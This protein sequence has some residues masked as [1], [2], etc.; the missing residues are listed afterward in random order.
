M[1]RIDLEEIQQRIN[2]N[3]PPL[4]EQRSSDRK[5]TAENL[6]AR[7][8][9]WELWKRMGEMYGHTWASQQGDEPN[10][11][12][13]RGLEGV[14]ND[15]LAAGLRGC[16]D[17]PGTFPPTL[18]EF[19]QMCTGYDPTAWE[20]QHHKIFESPPMIEDK[21]KKERDLEQ[22]KAMLAQLREQVGI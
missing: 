20:R 13:I 14:S 16:L 22:R 3:L 6:P 8:P 5:L 9:L 2:Q 12:W 19:R 17:R 15:Q 10:N 11:T 4:N 18:P 7:H 21:T 1:P